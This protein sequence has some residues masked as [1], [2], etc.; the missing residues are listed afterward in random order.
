MNKLSYKFNKENGL[1]ENYTGGFE[2]FI[3][4]KATNNIFD[5]AGFILSA[6]QDG[7][8]PMIV[9][10]CQT[11]GCCGLY[12]SVKKDKD[13]I[14]WEKFWHG[15]C[16][17][18]PEPDDELKD[19]QF[20]ENL[21]IKPPME[22]DRVEYTK[23]ASELLEDVKKTPTIYDWFSKRLERYKAGDLTA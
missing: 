8:F 11:F 20:T 19:F 14:I 4:G 5:E 13:K 18:T 16:C 12:V 2:V 6:E 23:L 22:F 9:G 21:T 15:Q 10:T 17:G 1:T 3:D 7:I